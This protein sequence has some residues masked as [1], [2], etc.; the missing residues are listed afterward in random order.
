M[1]WLKKNLNLKYYLLLTLV[2]TTIT[3]LVFAHGITEILVFLSISIASLMNQLML[4]LGLGILFGLQDRKPSLQEL[5][6]AGF[7]MLAKTVILGIAFY[8]GVLFIKNRIIIAL[9]IYIVQL[10]NLFLSIKKS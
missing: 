7:L 1:A 10:A 9:F 2:T 6:K 3:E 5:A 8:I 4:V